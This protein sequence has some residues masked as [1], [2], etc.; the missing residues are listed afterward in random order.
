MPDRVQDDLSECMSTLQNMSLDLLFEKVNM[1]HVSSW[2]FMATFPRLLRCYPGA[3]LAPTTSPGSFTELILGPSDS[4][5]Q[6][7]SY[8]SLFE[9]SRWKRMEEV[10]HTFPPWIRWVK[11]FHRSSVFPH[12]PSRAKYGGKI[13]PKP[14]P[15]FRTTRLLGCS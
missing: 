7:N 5:D 2:I 1:L 15:G 11:I 3:S 14:W 6:R 12:G 9:N 10:F 8:H 13:F 4:S